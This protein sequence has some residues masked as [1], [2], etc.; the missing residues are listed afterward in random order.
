MAFILRY[1]TKNE[2]YRPSLL[3]SSGEK[4]D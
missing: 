1:P 3:R 2:Y 4:G